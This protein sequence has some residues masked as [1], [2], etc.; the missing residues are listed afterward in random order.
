MNRKNSWAKCNLSLFTWL[1]YYRAML[2]TAVSDL[3]GGGC[4]T[5]TDLYMSRVESDGWTPKGPIYIL[6]DNDD[7]MYSLTSV[8]GKWLLTSELFVLSGSVFY[9]RGTSID[10]DCDELRI[11]STGSTD[12]QEVRGHGG[13]LYFGKT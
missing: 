13:S 9:G 1:T 6:D 8:T 12:F 4:G 7:I 2:R 11:Q 5:M 10:G 3:E